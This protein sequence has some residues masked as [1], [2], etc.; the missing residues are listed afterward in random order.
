MGGDDSYQ[1]AG[2][3]S[4]G[5]K[6]FTYNHIIH[7]EFGGQGSPEPHPQYEGKPSCECE[8]WHTT[9]PASI[10]RFL[11]QGMNTC[12]ITLRLKEAQPTHR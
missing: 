1:R 7:W 10:P 11:S 6:S 3:Q 12:P 2:G 4:M 8:C 9:G 5:L